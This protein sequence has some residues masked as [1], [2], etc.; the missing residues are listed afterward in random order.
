MPPSNPN[1]NLHMCQCVFAC[2]AHPAL[3]PPV[4]AG[5][6]LII[7]PVH[8]ERAAASLVGPGAPRAPIRL[9]WALAQPRRSQLLA[10]RRAARDSLKGSRRSRAPRP[11]SFRQLSHRARLFA[12]TFSP[13]PCQ[14]LWVGVLHWTCQCALNYIDADKLSSFTGPHVAM[15]AA[16]PAQEDSQP[17]SQVRSRRRDAGY[18]GIMQTRT[19]A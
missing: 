2:A 11:P 5:S 17:A 10:R 9:V 18:V 15:L 19:F 13:A 16:L 8:P 12:C 1:S 7:H 3:S 14:G 6:K 4:C